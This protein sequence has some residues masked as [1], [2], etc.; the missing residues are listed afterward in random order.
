MPPH[1]WYVG[2]NLFTHLYSRLRKAWKADGL[3]LVIPGPGLVV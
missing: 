1:D 3:Y 2:R